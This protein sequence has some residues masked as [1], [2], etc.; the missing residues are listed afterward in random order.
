MENDEIIV[1]MQ[2]KIAAKKASLTKTRPAWETNGVISW[3]SST[4][5]LHVL[6]TEKEAVELFAHLVAWDESHA[7]AAKILG[8][9]LEFEFG[10]FSFEKWQKDF[11]T[12]VT[13]IKE[14]KEQ[15]N[16]REMEK[17]LEELESSA[18][19]TKKSLEKIQKQ[20]GE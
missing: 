13:L 18:L 20:L 3:A 17:Q 19:K 10:G 8:S 9:E 4:K 2:E 12:R 1:K 7:K 6:G 15:A 11:Q 14:A 5:N 16:L